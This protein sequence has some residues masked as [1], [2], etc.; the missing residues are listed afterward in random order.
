MPARWT[1]LFLDYLLLERGLAENTLRAYRRDLDDYL[2]F[3]TRAGLGLEAGEAVPSYLRDLQTRGCAPA[4]RA[5]R[6][7][8][9]RRFYRF[10]ASEG[11][12][13]A[14]PTA[15]VPSPRRGL[16]LPRVLTV[17]EVDR[18]LTQP[19][20]S[21]P[22]GLRDRAML[23]LL[24]ATGLRV[25]ELVELKVADVNVAQGY[26]RCLGK[27]QRERVVPF[28]SMAARYLRAY[29]TEVR[30]RLVARRSPYLFVNRRGRP[31]SRQAMWK[32]IKKYA[33][34]AGID[35]T[36]GPHVLR[37][38]FATHLLENGADLRTVQELLGHAD[39]STTQI[40]THVSAAHLREVYARAHPRA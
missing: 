40:Y 24:Y 17:G 35:K 29:L 22:T 13:G 38:S 31:L 20:T 37:H 10:L 15:A 26:V 34:R 5:R 28:G 14:D 32:L 16:K 4:T 18:L 9:L 33:R 7:S 8:C 36:I 21:T 27:G 3:L 2:A 1:D 30:P 11:L 6:L 19:R 12:V 23:E 39:I 25:S